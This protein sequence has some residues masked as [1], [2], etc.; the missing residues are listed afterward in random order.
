[1]MAVLDAAFVLVWPQGSGLKLQQ[2]RFELDIRKNFFTKKV[3]KCWNRLPREV[4]ESPF[5]EVCKRHVAV[6]LRAMV[7]LAVLG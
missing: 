1:M 3:V 2:G 6:V 5:L 4:V 7:D